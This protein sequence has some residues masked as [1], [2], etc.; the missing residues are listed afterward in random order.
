MD[1]LEEVKKVNVFEEI[2]ITNSELEDIGMIIILQNWMIMIILW[3]IMII[4]TI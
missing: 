1:D 4:I 3:I 2:K